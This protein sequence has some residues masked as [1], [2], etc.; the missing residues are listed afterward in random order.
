MIEELKAGDIENAAKVYVEAV[1][2]QIPPGGISYEKAI[3]RV[4]DHKV[5]VWKDSNKIIGLIALIF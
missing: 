5:F 2:M 1:E 4:R 3:E